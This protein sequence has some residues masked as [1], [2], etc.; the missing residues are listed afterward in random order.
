MQ[1]GVQERGPK[2]GTKKTK[3]VV[4]LAKVVGP[5]T[6]VVEETSKLPAAT[7]I[8][9]SAEEFIKKFRNHLKIQRLESIDNYHKMLARGT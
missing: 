2:A 3:T 7:D 9:Q 4:P 6:K 8:D 5:L 1:E